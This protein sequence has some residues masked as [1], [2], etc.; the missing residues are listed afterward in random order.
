MCRIIFSQV[1]RHSSANAIVISGA[2]CLDDVNIAKSQS[3]VRKRKVT[4]LPHIDIRC[5]RKDLR[6]GA[7]LKIIIR[8]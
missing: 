1:P 7:K 3:D 2:I 8:K 6:N 4:T 5:H